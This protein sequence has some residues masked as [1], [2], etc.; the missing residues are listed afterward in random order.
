[1]CDF[2]TEHA[3]GKK[4][5]LEMR[6][7][8]DEL[9]HQE[10]SLREKEIVGMES[11]IQ[12]VQR[13]FETFVLPAAPGVSTRDK[14][15]EASQ[16]TTQ[17]AQVQP[18]EQEIVATRKI[19]HFGQVLPIEDVEEV[20]TMVSSI[21]R[22]PCGC[23][24]LLTGKTNQRYCFGFALDRIGI[25][26]N[27]PDAASSLEVLDKEEAKKIFRTYDAEGLVHSIWTGVTPY[28]VG[29]CNCDRDCGAYREY[30]YG[31]GPASFFKAEYVCEVDWDL[32]NGCKACMSQCQFGAQFYSSALAKVYI[33]PARCFGCGVCRVAC[34][35]EAIRILPRE[36]VPVAAALWLRGTV[37]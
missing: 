24:Y 27:F 22:M 12:W 29:L 25:L 21:T 33:D 28:V 11:R 30:I 26:G 3:E 7:Y 18:S 8:S 31:G 17:G 4:W 34:P 13:F 5:Y 35:K 6:N 14:S 9:L 32:C 20:I 37:K 10:L 16:T 1:M 36:Q 2:C 19:V 15:I 23:R